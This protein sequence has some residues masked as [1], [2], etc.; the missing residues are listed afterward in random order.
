M[1][2]PLTLEVTQGTVSEEAGAVPEVSA[3]VV[4]PNPTNASA[5]VALTVAAASDVR[6]S[7]YDVLGR[8]V[9]VLAEGPLNAGTHR[10]ALDGAGLPTGVY[11]VRAEGGAEP[12]VR[13]ITLVR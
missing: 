8:R 13:R 3:L 5:T 12:L 9:A 1:E 4:Y 11:V 7:V 2:V 6:V 10:F